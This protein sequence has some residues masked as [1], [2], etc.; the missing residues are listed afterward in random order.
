M[1]NKVVTSKYTWW[2]FIPKNLFEQLKKT[3]N[4]YFIFIC[5][6]QTRDSITISNGVPAN[7]GPLILVLLVSMAK[8]A[9]EDCQ[10]HKRDQSANR[11]KTIIWNKVSKKFET[12][13]WEDIR[14]GDYVRVD[15]SSPQIPAD[16]FLLAS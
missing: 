14:V 12:R 8:D 6:M 1:D 4:L 2:N 11:A 7:L 5:F 10:R 3:S 16:M 9:F 15:A 13:H